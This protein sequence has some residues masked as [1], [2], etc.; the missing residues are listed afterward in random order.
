MD[1]DK[2]RREGLCFKCGDQGHIGRNCPHNKPAQVRAA[3]TDLSDEGQDIPKPS[4][5]EAPKAQKKGNFSDE[6][7]N[8]LR[9]EMRQVM[10]NE[11]ATLMKGFVKAQKAAQ[12]N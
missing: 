5:K 6:M 3:T 9:E 4:S 2:A 8:E 7:R 1:I 12:A 10:S 11:F